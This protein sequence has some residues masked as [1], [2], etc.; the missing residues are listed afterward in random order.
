MQSKNVR[1]GAAALLCVAAAL[2][3]AFSYL[4]YFASDPFTLLRPT[5]KTERT[6]VAAVVL[7][8]DMG[9]RVGMGPQVAGRLVSS[10]IPVIGVNSLTYFRTT[11]DA[12]DA[13]ALIESAIRHAEAFGGKRKLILIG[14]SYGA[15]MLHVGLA[16]L[17]ASFRKNI[18]MVALVVPETTVDYRASPSEMLTFMMHEDDALPTARQLTWVPFLCVGG[19]EERASLCPLLRQRNMHSV[20]LPGGHSLHNDAA[21]VFQQITDEV[22]RVG[23]ASS[24]I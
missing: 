22:A 2:V 1:R 7:S 20:M 23:L 6:D 16:G 8:G 3:I 13:T 24:K 21:A 9:F 19:K 10:G 12:A 5:A 14:Q 11:R 15:D 17:P 18:A 4:G